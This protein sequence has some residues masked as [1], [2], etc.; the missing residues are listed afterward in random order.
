MLNLKLLKI[1]L[2]LVGFA[3][4]SE[5]VDIQSSSTCFCTT[6]PCPVSGNNYLTEGGGAVG[7]YF[8]VVQSNVPV[9]SSASVQITI[10]DLD[11]GTDTT[12]CTQDYSRSLDD[13][14][15]LL[16]ILFNFFSMT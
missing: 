15:F 5:I 7:T 2:V 9:V 4:S 13:V 6:V 14:L 11:K 8:Y 3:L 1:C 16:P 10:V 12:Q